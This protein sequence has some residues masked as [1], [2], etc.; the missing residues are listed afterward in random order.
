M[1]T[2]TNP[3]PIAP[4][5]PVFWPEKYGFTSGFFFCACIT[6]LISTYFCIS[7]PG[8]D[9]CQSATTTTICWSGG[10]SCPTIPYNASSPNRPSRQLLGFQLLWIQPM[11]I[12]LLLM[13]ELL[14]IQLLWMVELRWIQLTHL[15]KARSE[16]QSVT[17]RFCANPKMWYLELLCARGTRICT[18][19]WMCEPGKKL[20]Q[21]A[22][23]Q[24]NL[25]LQHCHLKLH[26][27]SNLQVLD[28]LGFGVPSG[29]Q[30]GLLFTV[31][32][33]SE[34]FPTQPQQV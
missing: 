22:S 27:H 24:G 32:K 9:A 7:L 16:R 33:F 10:R 26:I 4:G 21:P 11:W 20:N 17:G 34:N 19:A 25:A 12:L 2:P 3:T 30:T 31:E 18:E 15:A 29:D 5:Q 1:R 13:V 23:R 8:T 14:W 28:W 6:S